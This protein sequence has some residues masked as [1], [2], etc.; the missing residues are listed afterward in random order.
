LNF[1]NTNHLCIKFKR[2]K[3]MPIN[4]EFKISKLDLYLLRRI[5]LYHLVFDEQIISILFINFEFLNILP[6]I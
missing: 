2:L 1:N 4:Q 6:L 5:F 3:F